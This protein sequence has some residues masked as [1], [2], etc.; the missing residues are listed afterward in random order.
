MKKPSQLVKS[1]NLEGRDVDPDVLEQI[2]LLAIE[3]AREGREGRRI[4][5]LFTVGDSTAVLKNSR[6]LILDPLK[7]HQNVVCDAGNASVRE[8]I[9]E[10]ALLDGAFVV[11]GRGEFLS[12]CRFINA[13]HTGIN[14]P[15]GLGTRHMAAASISKMTKCV[16]V[17]VSESSMV[18]VFDDGELVNEII[19]EV[20]LMAKHETRIAGR[21]RESRSKD[22]RII[23]KEGKPKPKSK[24]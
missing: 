19:P 20:W 12:A 9:K 7:G 10:L 13:S 5:T 18:R 3:I 15:M 11:S 16:S 22:L 23:S 1:L 2:I 17:V 21:T 24:R 4:G 14:L 6:E 8:T